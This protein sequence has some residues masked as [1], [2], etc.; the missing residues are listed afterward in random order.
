[1]ERANKNWKKDKLRATQPFFVLESRSFVQAACRKMGISH[2]YMLTKDKGRALGTIPDACI[3]AV[4]SYGKDGEMDAFLSGTRLSYT[5]DLLPEA[6]DVFGVR[7]MPGTRPAGVSL[8]IRDLTEKRIP[9]EEAVPPGSGVDL[10]PLA[11]QKDFAGRIHVFLSAYTKLLQAQKPPA[12]YGKEA[13]F[14]DVC[15]RIYASDGQV[16]ISG[17]A[18]E[19]EYS[20]RYIRRIFMEEMGISPKTFCSILRF[21]RAIEFLNYGYEEKTA[22]WAIDLGYYDQPQCVRDFRRFIGMTPGRYKELITKEHYTDRARYV[23]V[24]DLK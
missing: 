12:P 19:T 8:R 13:L 23:S 6:E 9:I 16:R 18:A 24:P 17:L 22:D 5:H 1:M 4:F 3:D 11:S 10:R 14:Q 15:S 7:F 2:F 20:E 21:Q